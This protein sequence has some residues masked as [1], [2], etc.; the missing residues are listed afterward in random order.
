[1]VKGCVLYTDGGSYKSNPGPIGFG[2]HGYLYECSRV[3]VSVG[4]KT[5]SVLTQ[6]GYLPKGTKT[7]KLKDGLSDEESKAIILNEKP[8]LVNPLEFIEIHG[9]HSEEATNNAAEINAM[10]EAFKLLL[11][12]GDSVFY[13]RIISDSQ[14]VIK[15]ITEYLSKWKKAGW[16]KSDGLNVSNK[17]LWITIDGLLSALASANIKYDI[18]WVKGHNKNYGNEAADNLATIGAN[19]SQKM[20]RTNYECDRITKIVQEPKSFAS[21]DEIHP[22]LTNQ[23]FY[24]NPKYDTGTTYYLAEAGDKTE[25]WEFG[26]KVS[27]STLAVVKLTEKDKGIE[28]V[29]NAQRSIIN[30]IHYP[31]DVL[32]VG[33]LNKIS[34]KRLYDSIKTY[35]DGIYSTRNQVRP[36]LFINSDPVTEIMDPPFLS[37]VA[38]NKFNDLENY[39]SSYLNNK[40]QYESFD[41]TKYFYITNDKNKMGFNDNISTSDKDIRIPLNIENSH[42]QLTIT[43]NLGID[44]PKRN[45]LKRLETYHPKITLL[46]WPIDGLLYEYAI[47]IQLSTGDVG[48]WKASYS[49]NCFINKG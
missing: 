34:V 31:L 22:F 18:T 14:Y 42:L 28:S 45:I 10:I 15:G 16:T 5:N 25:D 23:R 26:K 19:L 7:E 27:D 36:D 12:L 33:F 39:L 3:K 13:T 17:G 32:V 49:G 24:F 47:I 9:Q 44:L 38:L 20:I 40:W 1:M 21:L 41:I 37:I 2:V 11:E 29:I 6:L 48:I 8:H 43:L 4:A 35:G 46:A 30:A